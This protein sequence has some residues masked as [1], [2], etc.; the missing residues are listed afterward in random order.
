MDFYAIARWMKQVAQ[1]RRPKPL[2]FTE[3][4]LEFELVQQRGQSAH[5]RV[6]I[7][8]ELRPDWA[9]YSHWDMRDLG[10]DVTVPHDQLL[11][12]AQALREQLDGFF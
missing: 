3:P 10:I 7:E 8:G 9:P 5:I 1:G 11:V 6:W 12:E 4:N 2:G